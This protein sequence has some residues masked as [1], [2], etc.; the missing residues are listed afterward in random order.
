MYRIPVKNSYEPFRTSR[1][2]IFLALNDFGLKKDD[3]EDEDE[4]GGVVKGSACDGRD[5]MEDD[6]DEGNAV[7]AV[8][9]DTP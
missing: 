3:E 1:G 7:V 4:D 5:V 8:A 6:D 9:L 2:G